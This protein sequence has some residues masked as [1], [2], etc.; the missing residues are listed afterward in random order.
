MQDREKRQ[1]QGQ[2]SGQDTVKSGNISLICGEAPTVLIE[3]KICMTGNL[4]DVI[5]CAMFTILQWFAFDF[6][7]PLGAYCT[8][9]QRYCAAVIP[10]Y[11]I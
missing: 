10:R 5:T 6:A 8:T 1:G 11:A 3:T 9:V 2:D 4:A 7:W